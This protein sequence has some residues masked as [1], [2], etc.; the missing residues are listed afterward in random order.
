MDMRVVVPPPRPSIMARALGCGAGYGAALG[1][2]TLAVP[3]LIVSVLERNPSALGFALVFSAVAA[4]AVIARS[5]DV[6]DNRRI[7]DER[8]LG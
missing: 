2:A 5:Y 1:V 3:G 8:H 6:S 4:L 7:G